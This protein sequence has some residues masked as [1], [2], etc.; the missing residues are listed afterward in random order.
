MAIKSSRFSYEC[1]IRTENINYILNTQQYFYKCYYLRHLLLRC[2]SFVRFSIAQLWKF[3]LHFIL[4][5][6]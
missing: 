4:N 5:L 3:I 6:Y 2:T 1:D